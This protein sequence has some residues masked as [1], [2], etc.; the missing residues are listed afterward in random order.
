[1]ATSFPFRIDLQCPQCGAPAELEEM[2]QIVDCPYCRVR[3]VVQNSPQLTVFIPPQAAI[4]SSELCFIPY[5]RF[6]GSAFAFDRTRIRNRVIDTSSL[7]INSPGLPHSLGLRSQTQALRFVTP[8]TPGNFIAPHV[9]QKDMRTRLSSQFLGQGTWGGP[10]PVQSHVGEVLS[11]IFAPCAVTSNGVFDGLT[12]RLLFGAKAAD[13]LEQEVSAPPSTCSFRPCL[14]PRCGWDLEGETDSHVLG[15]PG[16]EAMWIS[17]K[18]RFMNVSVT[19]AS[20]PSGDLWLPFWQFQ[21]RAS[22]IKLNTRAD[23]IRL[24]NL[25]QAVHPDDA[26]SE[27]CFRVPAFRVQP[28]IFLRLAR[29]VT[30]FDV[31]TQP[32]DNQDFRALHPATLP[33]QE[34]FQAILPLICDLAWDKQSIEPT[35]SGCRMRPTRSELVYMPFVEQRSEVVQPDLK[36]GFLKSALDLGRLL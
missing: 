3:H 28:A 27:L 26:Q 22:T 14:C 29:Q 6:K 25:P 16:C 36:T 15:C 5:W 35:L 11:L 12:G 31:R 20:G 19:M 23:L 18:N 17:H 13:L 9:P 10:P 24:A 21:V 8:E 34:G 33:L 7:A 1:M 4:P 30:V 32:F 2:Q